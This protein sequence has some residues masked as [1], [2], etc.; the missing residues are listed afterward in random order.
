[1]G[2]RREDGYKAW[3]K[4]RKGLEGCNGGRLQWLIAQTAMCDAIPYPAAENRKKYSG[5]SPSRSHESD[6]SELIVASTIIF[7]LGP[8]IAYRC[9][10]PDR[11]SS[12][13]PPL[14]RH[15]S[16]LGICGTS[17]RW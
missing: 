11:N 17:F 12:A 7:P 2:L 5:L 6:V 3:T 1:R 13:E 10:G 14:R 4:G 16:M 8:K 9:G 15:D